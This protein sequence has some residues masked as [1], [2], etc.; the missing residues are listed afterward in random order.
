MKKF[1]CL[2]LALSMILSLTACGE[3]DHEWEK[4]TCEEPRTCSKCGEEKGE[5]KDEHDWE[6]EDGEMVC[7]WCG[8]ECDH[9][10]EDGE[11]QVCGMEDPD[12]G[13]EDV[14]APDDGDEELSHNQGDADAITGQWLVEISMGEEL[15][16]LEGF[17]VDQ[18]PILFTFDGQGTMT[19]S[20]YEPYLADAVERIEDGMYDYLEAMLL[21]TFGAEGLSM[22]DIDALF[23]AQY[24]MSFQDFIVSAIK[25]QDMYGQLLAMEET[26]SYS[27]DGETLILDGVE[28][29][30][31]IEGDEMMIVSCLDPDFWME[32]GKDIPVTLRRVG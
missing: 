12:F 7:S 24:G 2:L 8:E 26:S 22:E 1:L 32:V 16:G 15:T 17:Q 21:E 5:P 27:F 23:R 30:V 10:F 31:V 13:S 6:D 19:M 3:C 18:L 9:E 28:M 25:E 4:A 20:F 29:T 11:C 14:P